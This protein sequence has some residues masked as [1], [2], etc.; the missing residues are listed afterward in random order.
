LFFLKYIEWLAPKAANEKSCKKVLT[1]PSEKHSLP[2]LPDGGVTAES[3]DEKSCKKLLTG[4]SELSSLP[5]LPESGT[6]FEK[7][8]RMFFDN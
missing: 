4:M 3:D 8:E 7:H 6:F 1:R 2:F 5:F